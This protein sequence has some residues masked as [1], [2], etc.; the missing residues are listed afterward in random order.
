[1]PIGATLAFV[2][3]SFLRQIDGPIEF[4]RLGFKFKGAAGQVVRGDLLSGYSGGYPLVL[5]TQVN[6]CPAIIRIGTGR[7]AVDKV[8][9][10]K[11]VEDRPE[12]G[13]VFLRL[14]MMSRE[15]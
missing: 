6:R 8:P 5:V 14:G 10:A 1:L 7:A 4:E 13:A 3:V 9:P 15:V 12:G 11:P 2:I